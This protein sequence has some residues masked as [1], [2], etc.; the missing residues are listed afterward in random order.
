MPAFSLL[1]V[2]EEELHVS[3]SDESLLVSILDDAMD[4]LLSWAK[5]G[6][7]CPSSIGS[8]LPSGLLPLFNIFW[9][10]GFQFL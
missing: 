9:G 4:N 6:L 7:G 8:P 1:P 2:S 10:E 3:K 5:V